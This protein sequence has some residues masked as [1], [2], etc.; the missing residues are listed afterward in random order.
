MKQSSF[1]GGVAQEW[2]R[3]RER[4]KKQREREKRVKRD[5]QVPQFEPE[6]FS[7]CGLKWARRVTE[8]AVVASCGQR[9]RNGG[10][11]QFVSGLANG[12]YVFSDAVTELGWPRSQ[13]CTPTGK[14]Q[15]KAVKVDCPRGKTSRPKGPSGGETTMSKQETGPVQINGSLALLRR[16]SGSQPI[17]QCDSN[18]NVW[19]SKSTGGSPTAYSLQSAACRL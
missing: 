18:C 16:P 7:V 4:W 14:Q 13:G 15:F 6:W 2:E 12:H 11:G 9:Q 8:S 17:E 5:T 10:S 3:E 1:L 19:R